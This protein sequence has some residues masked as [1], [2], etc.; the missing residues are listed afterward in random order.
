MN[1]DILIH[2]KLPEVKNDNIEEPVLSYPHH[3]KL[4]STLSRD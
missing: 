1:Q 4:T 2:N 3:W